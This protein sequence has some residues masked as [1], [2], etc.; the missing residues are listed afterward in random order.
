MK[1]IGQNIASLRKKNNITQEALAEICGV[2]PQAVSKWE[3]DVSCPD[4]A[5]LKTIARAF[6]VSVDELLDDGEGPVTRISENTDTTKKILRIRVTD[7]GNKV[8]VNLPFALVELFLTNGNL[9]NN[10]SFGKN[11]ESLKNIDFK[12]ICDMVHMGITGKLIEV[13]GEDGEKVEIWVE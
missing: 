10:I 12:Q 9:M 8:N 2:S 7:G 4:V 11:G 13:E 1:T 6:G 5:L 3:N